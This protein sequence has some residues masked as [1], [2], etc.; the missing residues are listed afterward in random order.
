MAR[1][2]AH[3]WALARGQHWVL[4]RQ[5]LLAI[6][7]TSEAID[8]RL[9][10]GR[11]HRVFAGVYAAGRPHVTRDGYLIA[12]VLACGTGAGLSSYSAGELYEMIKRRPGPVHVSVLAPRAPRVPGITVHRRRRFDLGT[13]RGIPVTS[14]VCTLIDLSHKLHDFQLERAINEAVNRDLVDLDELREAARGRSRA[15]GRLLDRDS[16]VVTDT[17]LEQRFARIARR[18]GLPRPETQARLAG[19]GVDFYWPQLDLV[20]EADSLRF[21]RTPFQQRTDVL[22]DHK[23][24]KAEI[25]T[26]RFTHWQIC[27]EPDY[28]E[29]ILRAA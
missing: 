23:N 10:Q 20:V 28:V 7:Y 19:G 2:S 14:P 25:R 1:K 17:V 13:Y 26:L 9:E 29:S 12:A 5:Q 16:F 15:V 21:H 6:G 11:L 18:A 27:R 4:T 8:V 3:A 24:F 22:R